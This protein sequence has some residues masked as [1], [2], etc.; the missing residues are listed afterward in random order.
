MSSG[1]TRG[2]SQGAKL[3][4]RGPAGHLGVPLVKTQKKVKKW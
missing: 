2:L 3:N 1:V 4:W